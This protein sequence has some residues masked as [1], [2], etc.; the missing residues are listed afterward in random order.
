MMVVSSVSCG[1]RSSSCGSSGGSGVSVSAVFSAV[2]VV[3]GVV[4][5]YE[6]A[7]GGKCS[8]WDEIASVTESSEGGVYSGIAKVSYCGV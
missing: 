4:S 5:V 2:M 8:S 6:D 1:A 7:S 3:V